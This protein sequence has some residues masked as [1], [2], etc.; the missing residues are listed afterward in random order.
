MLLQLLLAHE[1]FVALIITTINDISV[2]QLHNL[3]YWHTTVFTFFFIIRI[4]FIAEIVETRFK[5]DS[6]VN[7]IQTFGT[8]FGLFISTDRINLI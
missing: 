3:V 5:V 4:A 2:S 6:G 8:C 7:G 1:Y